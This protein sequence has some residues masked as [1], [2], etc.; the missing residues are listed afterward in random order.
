MDPRLEGTPGRRRRYR[1]TAM[2]AG[3]TIG[4]ALVIGLV[5]AVASGRPS[6]VAV[7]AAEPSHV[8][9]PPTPSAVETTGPKAT[10]TRTPQ[11]TPSV[12]SPT[13]SASSP[14]DLADGMYPAFI[15]RVDVDGAAVTVD[16]IQIFKHDAARRAAIQDGVDRSDAR[17]LPIYVRNENERLRTLPVAKEVRIRFMGVCLEAPNRHA[18]LT[19]LR[20]ATTPYD[21][22]FYYAVRLEDGAV[23]SLDQHL[24]IVAC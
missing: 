22:T 2:V 5:T 3:A 11:S 9:V 20:E 7:D 12:P 23:A 4:F 17:Y 15:R 19:E 14:Y 24:A 16:L 18:A 21:E 1:R 10:A 6:P 13:P 8:T